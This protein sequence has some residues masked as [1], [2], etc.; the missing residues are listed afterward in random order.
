[1][2]TSI[3]IIIDLSHFRGQFPPAIHMQLCKTNKQ[4][5]KREP[6]LLTWGGFLFPEMRK[7][8][9]LLA[10]GLSVVILRDDNSSFA[11]LHSRRFLYTCGYLW[12]SSS[13]GLLM[14]FLT[15]SGVFSKKNTKSFVRCPAPEKYCEYGVH[16]VG[17]CSSHPPS[18]GGGEGWAASQSKVESCTTFRTTP[19][20]RN[21]LRYR[22]I[23]VDWALKSKP[24][25]TI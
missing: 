16:Q 11:I 19:N 21:F 7:S 24:K 4:T 2:E 18:G 17:L 20:S 23:Q 13:K 12:D 25:T 9:V 15:S 22:S 14:S 8:Y 1:M 3:L 5:N 10:D 6:T